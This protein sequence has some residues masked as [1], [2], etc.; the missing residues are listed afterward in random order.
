VQFAGEAFPLQWESVFAQVGLVGLVCF[1][2]PGLYNAI[3]SMAGGIDEPA[4]NA[5]S[6]MLV[7]LSFGGASL[8]APALMNAIGPRHALTA[9][10][11]GYW[12][13]VGA[14]YLYSR[15]LVGSSAVLVG[16]VVCRYS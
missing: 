5:R 14:L 13:Y 6:N 9:G 8:L 7:Y 16:A 15:R 11:V 12:V 2:G 4:L 3:V 10:T 1:C